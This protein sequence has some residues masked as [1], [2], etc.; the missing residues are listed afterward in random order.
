MPRLLPNFNNEDEYDKS[1]RL[2]QTYSAAI[3]EIGR[4]HHL[5]ANAQLRKY[6]GGYM[7]VFAYGKDFAV[8]LYPPFVPHHF[9]NEVAFYRYL[10]GKLQL[11]TPAVVAVGLLDGWDY[12]VMEQLRDPLLDEAW[13]RL[14]A[15]ERHT[16]LC[17]LGEFTAELLKV[18]RIY[19]IEQI[20]DVVGE[21]NKQLNE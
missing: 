7:V 12:L 9:M 14:M 13:P 6:A 16:L 1:Q 8:K 5:P 21:I 20:C 3:E 11:Q 19:N 18:A 10:Q 17:E 15:D 2:E 4:R